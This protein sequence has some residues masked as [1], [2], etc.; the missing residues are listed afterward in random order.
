MSADVLAALERLITTMA[1]LRA[2]DGCPWDRE[3]TFASLAPYTVEEAYEVM[4]AAQRNDQDDLREELGDL[5]FQIVFY[6]RVAE[7]RGYF[8]FGDVASAIAEKLVRRHPH[9]FGDDE[10]AERVA[11]PGAWDRH[12]EEERQRRAAKK[13]E[14]PPGI[15]D[16]VANALPALRRAVKLQDRAARVGFD[17]PVVERVLEK[18]EEE[19]GELRAEFAQAD[20][21]R[22]DHELG[23]VL[24]AVSNVAR[25]IGVDP[26]QALHR[27]NR[28]F[29]QRFAGMEA[30]SARAGRRM[31]DW[32][33]EEQEALW[34]QAKA[35]LDEGSDQ[36]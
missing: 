8:D 24:L 22:L 36:V 32:T 10:N 4:D 20:P 29:E 9:V 18:V 27:A 28:R 15:L 30:L 21:A 19:I 23:D 11:M 12:K 14:R 13:G 25:H 31:E 1:R 5:L 7:E 35:E 34:V 17:W 26:E 3:Q 16:G 6:A 33:L 2:P